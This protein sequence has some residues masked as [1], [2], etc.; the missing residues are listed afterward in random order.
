[1]RKSLLALA[2]LVGLSTAC[3]PPAVRPAS[4][5]DPD[6]ACPGGRK[7]WTLSI[8]DQRADNEGA[9]QMT[10][11][12]RDGITKSFPG[13]HWTSAPAPSGETVVIE[14]HRFRS[15]REGQAGDSSGAWEAA[16]E[17]TVRAVDEGGRTLTEFQ[18]NEEVSRPNYRGSNNEKESLSEAYQKALERTVKGLAALPANGAIRLPGRTLEPVAALRG[19]SGERSK[20]SGAATCPAGGRTLSGAAALERDS[21][22]SEES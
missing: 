10:S 15:S 5:A 4:Y 9:E 22:S 19:G 17:W 21:Q 1:M 14:V 18:A 13:C 6:V 20:S 8:V 12:I 7:D 3:G 16:V 11:S 2:S